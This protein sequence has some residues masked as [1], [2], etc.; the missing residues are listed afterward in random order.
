MP[1]KKKYNKSTKS[2]ATKK[3]TPKKSP[4]KSTKKTY[5]KKQKG[6]E[7][8]G[9]PTSKKPKKEQFFVNL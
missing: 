9:T 7:G 5:T 2:K 3:T 8:W 6:G 1:D 4:S